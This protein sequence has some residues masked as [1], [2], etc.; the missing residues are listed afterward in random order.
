MN[1]NKHNFVLFIC[2][3]PFETSGTASRGSTGIYVTHWF[4]I[5]VARPFQVVFR[6]EKTASFEGSSR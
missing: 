3:L 6:K 5:Q 2:P 4:F 1:S